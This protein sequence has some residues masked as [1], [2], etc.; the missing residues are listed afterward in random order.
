MGNI[1]STI[2]KAVLITLV[3]SI[4]ALAVEKIRRYNQDKDDDDF[5]H[6]GFDDYD[7]W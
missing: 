2:A 5:Y 1:F 6:P 4:A 7:R 3:S